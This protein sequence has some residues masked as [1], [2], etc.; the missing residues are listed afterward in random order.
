MPSIEEIKNFI[1]EVRIEHDRHI[2][3][4]LGGGGLNSLSLPTVAS[5][6]DGRVWLDVASSPPVL[7]IFYNGTTYIFNGTA[8]ATIGND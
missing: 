4:S 1:R 3:D 6:V 8:Q 5:S 2:A 7:K